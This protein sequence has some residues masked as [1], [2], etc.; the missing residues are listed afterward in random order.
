[1]A[2]ARAVAWAVV[3]VVARPV[4]KAM[5]ILHIQGLF[6]TGHRLV[7]FCGFPTVARSVTDEVFRP[8]FVYRPLFMHQLL[9]KK[10]QF[11]FS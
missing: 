9:L 2:V 7:F 1:M 10:E 4:T 5:L 8:L 11:M 6:P 3:Q